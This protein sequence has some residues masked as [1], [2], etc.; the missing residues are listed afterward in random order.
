MYVAIDPR[1]SNMYILEHL[2]IVAMLTLFISQQLETLVTHVYIKILSVICCTSVQLSAL[3][4]R[5]T[6]TDV[7]HIRHYTCNLDFLVMWSTALLFHAV[8]DIDLL[9][10][11]FVYKINVKPCE[12]CTLTRCHVTNAHT[13]PLP[14]DSTTSSTR[15]TPV[16]AKNAD[17]GA[18]L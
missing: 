9:W 6:C 10:T 2:I 13:W 3:L 15:F 4:Q 17:S 8:Q 14:T 16:A 18:N 1:V 11:L 7:I 12:H 5:G